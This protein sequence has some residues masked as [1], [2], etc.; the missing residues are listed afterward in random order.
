VTT[1]STLTGYHEVLSLQQRGLIKIL[2]VRKHVLKQDQKGND[3]VDTLPQITFMRKWPKQPELR[4][5]LLEEGESLFTS[6]RIDSRP[7]SGFGFP[8]EI[9]FSSKTTKYRPKDQYKWILSD[10][11]GRSKYFKAS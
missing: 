10:C 9:D 8:K 2:E 6:L 1:F 3:Y 11:G 5:P 7:P 4:Q